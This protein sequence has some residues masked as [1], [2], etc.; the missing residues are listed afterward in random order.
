ML[1]ERG[2]QNR[3]PKVT[4]LDAV[5][6][7]N[8]LLGKVELVLKVGPADIPHRA[9]WLTPEARGSAVACQYRS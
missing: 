7:L 3:T 2:S 5:A 6:R 9:A 1:A 4:P 8:S